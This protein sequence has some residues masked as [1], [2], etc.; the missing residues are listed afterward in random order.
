MISILV[1][2][3]GHDVKLAADVRL[4]CNVRSCEGSTRVDLALEKEEH[5][6]I[7]ESGSKG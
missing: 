6:L 1:V 7:Q 3:E 4:I 2:S 5:L